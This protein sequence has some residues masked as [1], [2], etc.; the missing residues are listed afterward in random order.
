MKRA[1]TGGVVT[2]MN[3][4][5]YWQAPGRGGAG[6]VCSSTLP[7]S[8]RGGA[9]GLPWGSLGAHQVPAKVCSV[10]LPKHQRAGEYEVVA[11]GHSS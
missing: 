8:L 1:L 5:V 2:R 6:G 4:R 3:S 7:R 9:R 10:P 11:A